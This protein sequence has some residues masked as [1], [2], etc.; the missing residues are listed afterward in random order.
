MSI[1]SLYVS[2]VASALIQTA[3]GDTVDRKELEAKVRAQLRDQ[4]LEVTQLTCPGD[5]NVTSG[6]TLVCQVE[7]A[8][9]HHYE[10]E[11]A[12]IRSDKLRGK[13]TFNVTA[14]GGRAV[15][16][17]KLEPPLSKDI[18]EALGA[19]VVVKC[20][21]DPVRFLD[22]HDKLACELVADDLKTGLVLTF[23][24][25]QVFPTDWHL[26]PPL[27]VT[28]KLEAA[29]TPAARAKT[30]P[31]LEVECGPAQLVLRPADGVIWCDVSTPTQRGKM[32]VEID[33]KLDIQRWKI[34]SLTAR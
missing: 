29:V 14:R 16:V 19:Q 6:T 7:V 21:D 9:K 3:C 18:S 5:G 20:G 15:V 1:R 34:E 12:Y 13:A 11:V 32:S 24:R 30:V 26:E 31:E 33:G 17:S 2:V 22:A 25:K 28:S 8:G 23:D 4:G 10:L 27:I